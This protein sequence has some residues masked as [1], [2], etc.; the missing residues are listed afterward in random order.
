MES[1]KALGR[2]ICWI[3]WEDHRRSREL[4]KRLNAEY[5]VLRARGI[6]GI[7]HIALALKTFFVLWRKRHYTIIVQN[8]SRILAAVAAFLK[9]FLRYPLIV[10]RH[11]NF[12][13]GRS[14]SFN[15]AIWFVIACSEFS[16]R[17]AD[18]TI[19][20]NE[21]LKKI[22]EDKGGRAFVLTDP[23]PELSPPV[24]KSDN[25]DK[26][27]VFFVCTFSPDEPYKEVIEAARLLDKDV[28][29]RI[30]GNYRKADIN[31]SVLPNNVEFTGF[32]SNDEYDRLICSAGAVLALTTAEW[33]LVCGG[34]ESMGAQ[35]PL[36][37]SRT[38]TL[39]EYYG[40]YALFVEHE[41]KDIARAINQVKSRLNAYSESA[42]RLRR[43]KEDDWKVDFERFKR[44]LFLHTEA[45]EPSSTNSST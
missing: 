35:K 12:R 39:R 4:A 13:L 38:R 34:Y 44:A 23:I 30:S 20:T 37:T 10:D 9:P 45:A 42:Q 26:F 29:I 6:K 31:P 7:S 22:V 5:L 43:E 16:L 8:P 17:V 21:Y 15:P 18:L 36:I 1:D 28:Y 14:F 27:E 2:S 41:A 40:E 24:T 33:C 32:V 25:A 11:T 19:V 3:T